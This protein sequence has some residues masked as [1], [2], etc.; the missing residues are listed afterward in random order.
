MRLETQEIER[1]AGYQLDSPNPITPSLDASKGKGEGKA[2]KD[3]HMAKQACKRMLKDGQ[4]QFGE[5]CW[6]CYDPEVIEAARCHIGVKSSYTHDARQNG[7]ED[8]STSAVAI[9]CV[10]QVDESESFARSCGSVAET[11][12][13]A[14]TEAAH[15]RG[16]VAETP[17][18]LSTSEDT[19]EID[20]TQDQTNDVNAE[21][22]LTHMIAELVSI[23]DE[24][25]REAGRLQYAVESHEL[26]QAA[27]SKI[28]NKKKNRKRKRVRR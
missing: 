21:L 6:F 24:A 7:T 18:A 11:P 15:L 1:I 4:C 19:Y 5:L 25:Q 26:Q 28:K 13:A 10:A 22:D 27:R 2:D 12:C 14:G 9:S 8:I 16:S 23:N 3:K 20:W 17:C